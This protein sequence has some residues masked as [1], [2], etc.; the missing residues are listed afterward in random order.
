MSELPAEF[1]AYHRSGRVHEGPLNDAVVGWFQLW[2][3]SDLEQWNKN[4]E[5]SV[6][7]P[8]YYGIGSN[9]GGEMLAFNTAGAVYAL[10]FIGMEPGQEMLV[11]KSWSDFEALIG[12]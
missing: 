7:A 8:G 12:E 6:W 4:Y 10:P 2:P 9:G 11:A 1:V 3:F 5:A